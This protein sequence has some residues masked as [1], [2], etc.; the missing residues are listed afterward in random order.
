MWIFYPVPHDSG[1][2]QLAYYMHEQVGWVYYKL[3]GWL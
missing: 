2:E 3:R 1:F